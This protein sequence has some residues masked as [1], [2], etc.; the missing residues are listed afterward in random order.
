MKKYF[1]PF[2]VILLFLPSRL[3]SQDKIL[4]KNIEYDVPIINKELCQGSELSET[5][6]WK[7]NIETSKRWYFQQ[8]MLYKAIDGKIKVY[9]DNGTELSH[10]ALLNLVT[11]KDTVKAY[12][13][14]PP[15]SGYDTVITKYIS[16]SDIHSIRFRETWYYDTLTFKITKEISQYSP[17]ISKDKAVKF[18]NKT[19]FIAQ[20]VPLFWIKPSPK[21]DKKN[22]ITLTD[23]ISYNCPVFSN[24]PVVM[25]QFGNMVDVS[26]DTTD[27]RVYLSDLL[28]AAISMKIKA[29][30]GNEFSDYY[31][32]S[33]DSMQA[34]DKS[35]IL[36][37]AAICDTM[38]F[39]RPT[40]TRDL[41]DSVICKTKNIDNIRMLRFSEKWMI[42]TRTMDIQKEV[43]AISPCET[44][45]NSKNEFK[46][47]RYLFTTMFVKPM[48]CFKE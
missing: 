10:D 39:E 2:I 38:T 37:I 45:Y 29:Y 6:W 40:P 7:R 16:P 48:R 44:A 9:D 28:L 35:E 18:L 31:D 14:K 25:P 24:M 8:A 3:C 47:V 1:I 4:I 20:D 26:V 33:I 13:K 11:Y 41:I 27:R 36:E 42:D 15:Y 46:G 21:A 32:F 5:D 34:Y 19:K 22:F 30:P 12:R 17:L 23:Y 43:I